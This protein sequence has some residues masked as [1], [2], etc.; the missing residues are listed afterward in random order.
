MG[1]DQAKLPA[2][3][4]TEP[5]ELAPGRADACTQTDDEEYE[6]RTNLFCRGSHF[7]HVENEGLEEGRGQRCR[8][9]IST[10]VVNLYYVLVH[11]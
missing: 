7:K 5:S 11:R 1:N 10:C 9:C 4:P 8:V 6:V 2:G 3:A